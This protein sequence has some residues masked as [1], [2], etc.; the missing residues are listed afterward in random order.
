MMP[1]IG[2][3][4]IEVSNGDWEELGQLPCVRPAPCPNSER[5]LPFFVRTSVCRFVGGPFLRPLSF[6]A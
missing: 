5:G 6:P 2:I 3:E 1:S 4:R